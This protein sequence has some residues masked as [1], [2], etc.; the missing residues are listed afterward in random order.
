M[1]KGDIS[2]RAFLE[3]TA[4]G[5]ASI[6][7]GPKLGWAKGQPE[8]SAHRKPNLV[9]VFAD[10]WRAQA[11][12]YAGDPN[13]IT[14]HLDKLT[15][16]SIV[17]TTA[18]SGC[19]VCSPYRASLLTGQYPLTHG[20]FINDICL[21]NQAVSIAEVY[22]DAGYDTGY[23]GKWHLAGNGRR[24]FIPKAKRQG[25]QFWKV[26]ECTHDYPNSVYYADTNE[27]LK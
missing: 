1:V 23:I 22:N 2:R 4:M 6:A 13:A 11:T 27:Q 17:F 20:V 26:C 24:D 25:F 21:N 14:P 15:K 10:Q 19:P 8:R 16:E 5:A 12:G 7:L 18:V 9:F 3:T